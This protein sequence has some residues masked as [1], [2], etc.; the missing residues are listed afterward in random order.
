MVEQFKALLREAGVE[1]RNS[2]DPKAPY[3]H[4]VRERTALVVLAQGST[5]KER[6]SIMKTQIR[7]LEVDAGYREARLRS[8]GTV[9]IDESPDRGFWIKGN[10]ILVLHELEGLVTV[11]RKGWFLFEAKK[12]RRSPELAA[13]FSTIEG[14]LKLSGLT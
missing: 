6:W 12:L 5:S 2:R 4:A 13:Y 7:V 3:F 11:D 14:F 1:V 9:L 8:W 10:N